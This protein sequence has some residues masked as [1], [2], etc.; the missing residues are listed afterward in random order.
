MATA[1]AP[2]TS[3]MVEAMLRRAKKMSPKGEEISAATDEDLAIAKDIYQGPTIMEGKF[4]QGPKYKS[5]AQMR[6]AQNPALFGADKKKR[7]EAQ[8]MAVAGMASPMKL[9]KMGTIVEDMIKA[10]NIEKAREFYQSVLNVFRYTGN[11]KTLKEVE[12]MA[13][14]MNRA[15]ELMPTMKAA[16]AKTNKTAEALKKAADVLGENA[17]KTPGG[18]PL[19]SGKTLVEYVNEAKKAGATNADLKK[20]LKRK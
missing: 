9:T 6:A 13:G 11:P 1:T 7:S 4:G 17:P 10:G 3:K 14:V 12:S 5:A 8:I 2:E 18:Y 19:T 16:A 15:D 20:M